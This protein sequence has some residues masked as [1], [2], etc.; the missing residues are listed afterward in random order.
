MRL[1]LKTLLVMT[2]VIFLLACGK[3]QTSRQDVRSDLTNSISLASEAETLVR[4]IGQG[5]STY[6]FA[7]G[8]LQYL[9]DEVNKSAQELS[10]LNTSPD[11]KKV[12]SIDRVQLRLLAIQIENARRHLQQPNVLAASEQKIRGIRMTLVQTKSSL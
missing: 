1:N 9:L 5:R 2:P 3:G 10:N 6:Y 4:Y 12:M 8:H 7:F 11:L